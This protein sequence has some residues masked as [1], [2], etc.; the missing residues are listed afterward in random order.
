MTDHESAKNAVNP[1]LENERSDV[2]AER[3]GMRW[4]N[5]QEAMTVLRCERSNLYRLA[6]GIPGE[7]DPWP[8]RYNEMGR[9]E[10]GMTEEDIRKCI[11][12]KRPSKEATMLSEKILEL[13]ERLM[14]MTEAHV[15]TKEDLASKSTELVVMNNERANFNEKIKH[16]SNE[17]AHLREKISQLEGKGIISLLLQRRGWG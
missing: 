4:L 6:E 1:T 2:D 5:V 8:K 3:G 11:A 17:N 14:E 12:R 15:R 7:R 13:S 16:L 10:F 9:V